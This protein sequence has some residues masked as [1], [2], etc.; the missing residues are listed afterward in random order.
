[1]FLW[2][3][4]DG[5]FC[6][7]LGKSSLRRLLARPGTRAKVHE[8]ANLT[9]CPT[10]GQ[11][12]VPIVH[13]WHGSTQER[14]YQL[15]DQLCMATF[16]LDRWL[17]VDDQG[18]LSRRSWSPLVQALCDRAALRNSV[19]VAAKTLRCGELGVDLK[20]WCE[21]VHPLLYM[22][23]DSNPP[24]DVQLLQRNAK[25]FGMDRLSSPSVVEDLTLVTV[26]FA[27]EAD[28]ARKR[29]TLNAMWH[30][31][32][33]SHLPARILFLE[34]GFDDRFTFCQSDFPSM[35]EY[36]RME[37]R[38]ENQF[39]F[40][41]ECL[42]N[43]AAKMADTPKL[44]FLDSDLSP[45]ANCDWFGQISRKLDH[46]LFLQPMSK[47]EYTEPDG[48]ISQTK[49]SY[50]HLLSIGGKPNW[51]VGVPGGCHAMRTDAFLAMGGFSHRAFLSGGDNLA[52]REILGPVEEPSLLMQSLARPKV[53]SDLK[54]LADRLHLD[55]VCGDLDQPC[56]HFNHRSLHMRHPAYPQRTLLMAMSIG[57][58]PRWVD[59]E[60]RGLLRWNTTDN[61]A[62]ILM[63]NYQ[64]GRLR[65]STPMNEMVD[66]TMDLRRYS[67]EYHGLQ[68]RLE[69]S[70]GPKGAV[71]SLIELNAK[72]PVG[73]EKVDK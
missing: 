30:W 16:P 63:Q 13:F 11:V 4:S 58:D 55:G 6:G 69:K 47:V 50:T 17:Q 60:E 5:R 57:Q 40:Q 42:W 25:R 68:R 12:D 41:K 19:E 18:L 34:L 10:M 56:A 52:I 37:G 21:W 35:V 46:C 2:E 71:E 62:R 15:R 65:A 43:V 33:Q 1:M 64:A 7:Q 31:M 36:V 67:G 53:R 54:S 23:S 26:H 70:P 28:E 39:L 3:I 61:P 72:F 45:M 9:D 14:S 32:A 24:C 20:G 27:S 49:D 22:A 44:L 59:L 51:K 73:K 8:L 48:T 29:S 38:P 66:G